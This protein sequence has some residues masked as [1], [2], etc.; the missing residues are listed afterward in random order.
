MVHS[1]LTTCIAKL[2]SVLC[3]GLRPHSILKFWY[4]SVFFLCGVSVNLGALTFL[5]K[6]RIFYVEVRTGNDISA[7]V[8]KVLL[9]D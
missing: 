9:G 8:R 7:A 5:L 2:N 4:L 6:F 1:Y 3:E